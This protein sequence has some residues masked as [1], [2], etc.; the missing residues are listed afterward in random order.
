VD[1]QAFLPEVLV[2]LCKPAAAADSGKCGATEPEGTAAATGGSSA[3][4]CNHQAYQQQLLK[5]LS[6]EFVLLAVGKD[7]LLGTGTTSSSS[8]SGS[9]WPGSLGEGEL[10][11]DCGDALRELMSLDEAS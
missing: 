7:V 2:A 5:T 10:I 3:T 9:M 6:Q 1:Y 8:A 11:Q 4:R